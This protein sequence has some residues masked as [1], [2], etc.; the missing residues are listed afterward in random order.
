M[1]VY[2]HAKSITPARFMA[3]LAALNVA[4]RKLGQFF[5][6]HEIWLSPTTARVA[7]PFGR[8]NLSKP[9]VGWHNMI[10]ELFRVPVQFTIPHNIMGTPGRMLDKIKQAG[11]NL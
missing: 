7:E 11:G 8:Y 6:R 5:T 9:G 3:A 10:D 2:E 4:R 1:S